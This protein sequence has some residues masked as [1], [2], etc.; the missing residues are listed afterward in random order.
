MILS[1]LDESGKPTDWWFMY[2]APKLNAAAGLTDA[3]TG[4][5]YVYFD[6]KATA[7]TRSP[8][9]LDSD[10]GALF[11]TLDSVFGNPQANT[12]WILYND[13]IPN[14]ATSLTLGHSKGV[15]G[16]DAASN[17]AFWLVHSW[18]KFPLPDDSAQPSPMY[19]QT[20]LCVA[21]DLDQARQLATQMHHYQQPQVYQSR[22]PTS[23]ATDDPLFLLKHDVIRDNDPAGSNVL[24]LKSIGGMPLK[25]IAKNAA[26]NDDFW[27]DIR[28]TGHTGI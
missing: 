24:E 28:M 11:H 6:S 3:S 22:I 21:L 23:F 1:P 17:T 13:E 4:F 16:F 18:P 25:V 2:K 20:Y 7:V 15:I 26:W 27:N 14:G 12:G 19:G 9:T 5:E 8:Y 10:N